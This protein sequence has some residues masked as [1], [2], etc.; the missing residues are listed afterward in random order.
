LEKE[1]K[2]TKPKMRYFDHGEAVLEGDNRLTQAQDEMSRFL[3]SRDDDQM[4]YNFREAAGLDTKEAETMTGWDAPDGRLSGHTTGHY[5]SALALCYKATGDQKRKQ[6]AEYMI[7]ELEK[8][9]EAMGK[10]PGIHEGFLSGYP[11]EQFDKLEAYVPYPDI[12]A[13]YYTLHKILAG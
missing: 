3:L 9:Q 13:P 2:D 7:R 11:E 1:K 12:W 4:L 10:M 8:C 6:K 5:L